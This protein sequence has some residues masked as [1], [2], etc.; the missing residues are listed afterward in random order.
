MLNDLGLHMLDQLLVDHDL[1][2]RQG[3]KLHA[4]VSASVEEQPALDLLTLD[5]VM[6]HHG[7]HAPLHFINRILQVDQVDL[8][9][10]MHSLTQ[11]WPASAD[12]QRLNDLQRCLAVAASRSQQAD[13]PAQVMPAVY[14]LSGAQRGRIEHGVCCREGWTTDRVWN[15]YMGLRLIA[16]ADH[17][18]RDGDV[19][20]TEI[21]Q[22]V[23]IWRSADVCHWLSEWVRRARVDFL[24]ICPHRRLEVA[25]VFIVD[26]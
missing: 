10:L 22:I 14:P 18:P 6:L 1:A 16:Y 24:A 21:L 17:L 9:A 25:A 12:G 5:A 7:Q 20:E 23:C 11:Q 8:G 26:V 4:E 3:G 19:R 13:K 2:T 15:V